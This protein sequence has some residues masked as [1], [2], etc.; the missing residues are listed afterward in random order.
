MISMVV[1]LLII[2]KVMLSQELLLMKLEFPDH[3]GNS[4]QLRSGENRT[5][6]K[7]CFA[8]C[9]RRRSE[10]KCSK[11]NCPT[12]S[13]ACRSTP[14]T[15]Q[16][17]LPRPPIRRAERII[18][19]KVQLLPAIT[20]IA[21]LPDEDSDGGQ[22]DGDHTWTPPSNHPP[23]P[24]EHGSPRRSANARQPSPTPNQKHPSQPPPAP[25]PVSS[26]SRPYSRPSNRPAQQ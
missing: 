22:P 24:P 16:A 20:T 19:Q 15:C 5:L 11:K 12:P 8:P 14:A 6:S 2:D 7:R 10:L 21:K 3:L 23:W 9:S 17:Q 18:R 4:L 25:H 13:F 26:S 1:V